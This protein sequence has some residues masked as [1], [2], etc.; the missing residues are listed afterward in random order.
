[1]SYNMHCLINLYK[2]F[3]YEGV[4]CMISKFLEK[5]IELIP[6]E[7]TEDLGN[8]LELEYYLVEY[9]SKEECNEIQKGYGI[10]IIKKNNGKVTESILIR[11]VYA[12]REKS[13]SLIK[14]LFVN[15]V[16]PVSLPYV[17][18]DL[19]GV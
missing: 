6:Q 1:M 5:R 18:D 7:I 8:P 10:E 19:I 15:S 2:F 12:T 3:S 14:K 16:T 11:N 17:L 9:D 13:E 4:I